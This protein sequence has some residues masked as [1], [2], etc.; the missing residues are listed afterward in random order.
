MVARNR[1]Y[2]RVTNVDRNRIINSYLANDDFLR[3]AALLNINSSTAWSIVKIYQQEG[4]RDA[5]P[6][7]GTKNVKVSEEMKEKI[8]Q[9]VEKDPTLTLKAINNK[10]RIDLPDSPEIC[11]QSISNCLDGELITLKKLQTTPASW[12]EPQNK[13][14]RFEFSSW[15]ITEG[16]GKKLVYVDEFGCNV[17]TSRTFGRARAGLPAVRN[18]AGQR[19][20]NL[21]T[22]IAVS[23][24]DG[25]LHAKFVNGGMTRELFSEFA[26]ELSVIHPAPM[27]VVL[28]NARCHGDPPALDE[29]QEFKFLS[30]YSPFFNMTEMS[31]SVIKAEL[32]AKMSNPDVQA[33]IQDRQAA[34]EAGVNLAEWRKRILRREVE[35]SLPAMTQEKAYNQFMH[36]LTYIPKALNREDIWH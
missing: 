18:V 36:T 2:N 22:C 27:T 5:K 12:N 28:D 32:K 19:G 4:R 14:V 30:P 31:I 6:K 21:T 9:Y 20:T 24:N 17:Y 7:G 29:G 11:D 33:E 10:L 35:A 26:S 34:I 13:E 1:R 16:V 15:L 3:F 25:L 23:P 8:I